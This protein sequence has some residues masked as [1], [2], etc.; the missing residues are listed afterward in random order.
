M[1]AILLLNDTFTIYFIH[2]LLDFI[3][4]QIF[5]EIVYFVYFMKNND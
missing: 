5:Y 3:F 4:S 1:R 2:F